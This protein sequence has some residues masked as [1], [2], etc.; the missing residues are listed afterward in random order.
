MRR[1]ATS[2][3]IQLFLTF[4]KQKTCPLLLKRSADMSEA[5][6]GH[7]FYRRFNDEGTFVCYS[8]V[9]IRDADSNEGYALRKGVN[10]A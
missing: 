3:I 5:A 7:A 6:K 9:D 10:N 8:Q 1:L 4:V 2:N